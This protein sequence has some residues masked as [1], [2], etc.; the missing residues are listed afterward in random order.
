MVE[1]QM[2]FLEEVIGEQER[3][4]KNEHGSDIWVEGE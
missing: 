3:G 1:K 2:C 4:M